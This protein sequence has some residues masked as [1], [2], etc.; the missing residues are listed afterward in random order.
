VAGV[1]GVA[2]AMQA[3][4]RMANDKTLEVDAAEIRMRAERRL[5]EMLAAQKADGGLSKGQLKQGPAL[6]SDEGGKSAPKLADAGISY[7]LSSRAQKLAAVREGDFQQVHNR[8]T[9]VAKARKPQKNPAQWP[10]QPLDEARFR[11]GIKRDRL[12]NRY[13]DC[14]TTLTAF[15][16]V[17]LTNAASTNTLSAR[18]FEPSQAKQSR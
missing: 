17:L 6:V 11:E 1:A 3:Y 16:V 4:G 10:G 7:D 2:A 5:G 14:R 12:M 9:T 15:S 13:F 18:R 8:N